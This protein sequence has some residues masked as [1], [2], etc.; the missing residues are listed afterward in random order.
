M[1][2]EPSPIRENGAQGKQQLREVGTEELCAQMRQMTNIFGEAM[3]GPQGI[4]EVAPIQKVNSEAAKEVA[5]T[6]MA[7][8]AS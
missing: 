7:E 2:R 5:A 1:S 3:K 4:A 6:K 8:D